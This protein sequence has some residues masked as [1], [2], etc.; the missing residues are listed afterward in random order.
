MNFLKSGARSLIL[1]RP[2]RIIRHTVWLLA[3][4]A[5]VTQVRAATP[6]E[7]LLPAFPGAEGFGALATGG[8]GGEIYHVT[9]LADAGAG[10]FRDALSQSHRMVVFDVGG[11]IALESNV[12]CCSDITILGQTAPGEGIALYGRSISFS[13]ASNIIVRYLRFRE[14]LAGSRGKCSVNLAHGAN[15]I[16]DHVSI[17]WG[18]WDCL[19]LTQ[20]S[21]DITFQNCLIGQGIGPQ[22]FGALVDSVTNITFSHNLWIDNKSRNPKAKGTVQYINNVIYNWGVSGL[23]GGHSEMDHQLDVIGNYFIGGPSSNGQFAGM[24]TSTDK[25]FLQNNYADLNLDGRLDGHLIGDADFKK[26]AGS[27]VIFST[28]FLHP[29]VPVVIE[30]AAT[31]W[32]HVAAEAGCSLH[33]DAVDL[34][35]IAELRSLGSKGR[36]IRDEA[37]IG[38]MPGLQGGPAPTGVKND[39]IPDAWKVAHGLNPKNSELAQEDYNHDGYSNLEKYAN[40]LVQ[41][42]RW[43]DSE[44]GK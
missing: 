41:N 25:V 8:R 43:S 7:T 6:E 13:G 9:T 10:S 1:K 12:A 42:K 39:G 40:E 34:Q 38:G 22:C 33:R 27:P 28:P 4:L 19:D 18:R 35:L 11:V 15:M 29:P 21:H 16:F 31:A 36:I 17:E 14:G 23:V 5:F 30:S 32:Q 3:A 44:T 20:G 24:F 26:V 2:F 37:E